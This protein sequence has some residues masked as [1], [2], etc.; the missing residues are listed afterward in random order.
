MKM[1]KSGI[2][3]L[4]PL[5]FGCQG[6]GDNQQKMSKEEID[7]TQNQ[8]MDNTKN[9]VVMEK[10]KLEKFLSD[11]KISTEVTG[12]GLHY[13][14]TN[15]GN[16]EKAESGRMVK[17]HYVGKFLDGKVFDSSIERGEPIDF[18]LGQGRVIKGWDEGIALLSEGD[19]ATLYIPS[20][21]AYGPGGIPNAIPPFSTLIFDVE[22]VEVLN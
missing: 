15:K 9:S 8:L 4:I 14:I 21:L 16:G 10:Q 19:K 13:Q 17:V 20:H 3:L 11:N 2:I 6:L 1:V 22:L 12:T 18:P 7:S 5:L